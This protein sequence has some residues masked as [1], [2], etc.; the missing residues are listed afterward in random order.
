MVIPLTGTVALD[1]FA[2]QLDERR[3]VVVV[4]I[5]P[6]HLVNQRRAGRSERMYAITSS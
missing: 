2:Q 1:L 5:D 4:E 6:R 3:P